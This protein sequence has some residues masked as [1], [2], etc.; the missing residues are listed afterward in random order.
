MCSVVRCCGV[1]GRCSVLWGVV[2]YEVVCYD[3][4]VLIITTLTDKDQQA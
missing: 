4:I 2:L 3:R 1:M